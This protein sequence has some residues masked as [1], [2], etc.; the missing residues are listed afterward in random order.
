[1]VVV[2][3]AFSVI[4]VACQGEPEVVEVTRVI[5]ETITEI[6]EQEGETVEV[7]VEVTRV[8]TE[9][10]VVEVEVPAE[11]VEEEAPA[12][13]QCC[14]ETFT[15][16]IFEDPLT[17]NYWNSNGPSNSVWTDYITNSQ[18]GFLYELSDQRF[19]FVPDLAADLPPDPV[20][21]GDNWTI[22]VPMVQDAVWSDGEAIDAHDV[23]FTLNTSLDLKLTQGWVDI[24]KP[25]DLV[26]AEVVDDYTVKF[27]FNKSP[28]LSIWQFGIAQHPILPEHFWADAVAEARAF[29][30][31]MTA[32]DMERP[33]D[34]EAEDADADA[35]GAWKTYDEAFTNARTVLYGADPT[36]TPVAGSY[37]N[38]RLELG[39][40]AQKTMNPNY[41]TTGAEIVE[42]ADGSW[43]EISASGESRTYYG[44][45]SG[46]ETLRYTKGPYSE[47]IIF[48]IYGDQSSAY[49]ALADGELDYVINPLSVAR[50]LREQA[51][52]G[53][54][55]M[56]H[57]N[58]DNGLFYMAFNFRREPYGRPE[59]RQ[60]VDIL[61]DKEFVAENVLQGSIIPAYSVVPP[62][63][64]AWYNDEIETPYVGMTRAE[65]LTLAM[66]VLE[67]AGW[68]WDQKPEWDAENDPIAQNVVNGSGIRMPN[69]EL[70]PDTTLIGPG[71]AYDPQRASFNQ[72]IG[73]W[74]RELGMPVESEL[75]GFNTI[76]DPVFVSV[77]FDIYILGWSLTIYPDHVCTFF[78]SN[79]DT[80]LFGGNNTPGLN[81]PEFDA[82]CDEFYA[83]TDF[84]TAIEQNK[85]LQATV[86][87]L[88]PYIP[89]FYRQAID[90]INSRVK[91][92]YTDVLGGLEL[93]FEDLQSDAQVLIK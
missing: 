57:V 58:A 63:N 78:H 68:T 56:T 4:L 23:A 17:L 62:G 51:Q 73:E 30:E 10:V 34:C 89:L 33:E 54:G 31:G 39:A 67:D 66:Q 7:E 38:D 40:F 25:A 59:F 42:T 71:P 32:P 49:L 18:A 79:Q 47:N 84:A 52:Q 9:E 35:C 64:A 91:V 93:V 75:T 13:G 83:E 48:S 86:A 69:G 20:Q 88:R 90:M 43:T 65:R 5:T 61:V 24:S 14:D 22:T 85:A 81:D 87:G 6:V 3:L 80:L 41:Y 76:L 77:D 37:I 46:E 53:E 36:G 50:G 82:A 74:M 12:A 55:V 72:W 8:V 2:L 27:I 44:D 21:E 45:G 19:D 16:G 60:A 15:I 11:V 26:G 92:P 28:G 70:M 29:I 1:M